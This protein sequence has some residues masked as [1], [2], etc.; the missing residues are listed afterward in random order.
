MKS[1]RAQAV[2]RFRNSIEIGERLALI[3]DEMALSQDYFGR[4]I[5]ISRERLANFE[6]G[7]T[8]LS[9]RTAL[10]ICDAYV[11]SEKWLATGAGLKRQYMDLLHDPVVK[12]LQDE[13]DFHGAFRKTLGIRYEELLA[14]NPNTVRFTPNGDNPTAD[15]NL[16]DCF[17]SIW[18]AW[19]P[20]GPKNAGLIQ[21][22]IELGND[23]CAN[24]DNSTSPLSE[25]QILRILAE[26]GLPVGDARF[27]AAH[28]LASSATKMLLTDTSSSEKMGTVKPL[29]SL[30]ARANRLTK[31]RGRKIELGNAL[32]VAPET[33]SRYLSGKIEPGGE[34]TLRLLQWVEQQERK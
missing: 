12:S 31:M 8:P 14:E 32:G 33:V 6:T 15:T 34:T 23:Y 26:E 10:E 13:D 22:I 2:E 7:R 17:L 27:L 1:S 28:R 19:L 29:K 11:I 5:E 4:L 16:I 18:R 30:L 3:R 20:C 25:D 9:V 21:S 24:P